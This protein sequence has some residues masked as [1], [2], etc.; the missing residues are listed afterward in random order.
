MAT[1]SG[2]REAL[3]RLDEAS[4]VLRAPRRE[5]LR[6]SA[7]PALGSKWLVARVA[8][9]DQ[10]HC[11]GERSPLAKPQAADGILKRGGVNHDAD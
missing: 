7:A 10:R 8:A 5:R 6:I 1:L 11:L 3:L 2:E 9:F 4:A